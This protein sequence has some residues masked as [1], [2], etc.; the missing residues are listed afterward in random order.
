VHAEDD[1]LVYSN[2]AISWPWNAPPRTP[3]TF[4]WSAVHGCG[5]DG[6]GGAVVVG[7][8][9]GAELDVA[10]CVG[11]GRRVRVGRGDE[12]GLDAGGD[13][14]TGVDAAGVDGAALDDGADGEATGA[15]EPGPL[16]DEVHAAATIAVAASATASSGRLNCRSADLS[17]TAGC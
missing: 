7:G 8:G 3:V 13:E 1:V 2:P 5:P 15:D 12:D 10:E 16:T 4:S 9:G 6:G 14:V 17:S 11:R